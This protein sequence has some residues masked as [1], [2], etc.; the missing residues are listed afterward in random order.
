MFIGRTEAEALVF[1]PP[2]A[3]SQLIGKDPDAGKD[4]RQEKKGRTE[5]KMVGWHHWLNG[6]EFEQPPGDSERQG[7]AECCSPWGHKESDMT[8]WLNKNN[9]SSVSDK[10]PAC[11]RR[12][13][14]RCGWLRWLDDITDSMDMS[15]SKLREKD[16]EAWCAPWDGKESDTTECLNS[17][18]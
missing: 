13:L 4:W 17:N 15:L 7:S 12:R 2:D 16:R 14:K 6:H 18:N 1:W 3:K 8:E 9:K 5:S 11:Q 10:E